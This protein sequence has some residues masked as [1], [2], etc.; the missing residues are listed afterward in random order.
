V[1]A[2]TSFD[3]VDDEELAS[4]LSARIAGMG[5]GEGSAPAAQPV[6][7][8]CGARPCVSM[9]SARWRSATRLPNDT[10]LVVAP[11]Q[12]GHHRKQHTHK[13]PC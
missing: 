12:R 6:S 8:L 11:P 13:A 2:S 1:A 4:S 9:L 3:E 10:E 7:P 5:M